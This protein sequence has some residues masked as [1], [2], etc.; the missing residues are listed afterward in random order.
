[1]GEADSGE[2]AVALVQELEPDLVLMDVRMPGIGGIAATR[3][4]KAMRESTIVVLISTTHPDE[5]PDDARHSP[6]DAIIWKGDLRPLSLEK[7]WSRHN[8]GRN[9]DPG[10][11][12]AGLDP[13]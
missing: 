7:I 6:A 13:D 3:A 4:I 1:V 5:L 11:F 2:T 10:R 9:E 8:D 12:G